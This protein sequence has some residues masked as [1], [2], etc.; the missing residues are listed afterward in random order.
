MMDGLDIAAAR[1]SAAGLLGFLLLGACASDAALRPT[2]GLSTGPV[3]DFAVPIQ[4]FEDRRFATVVRQQY[5]FSCGSAALATLLRYHYALNQDEEASF[6]GMWAAGDRAQIRRVGFSLLDM[7]RHLATL[8]YQADGF[9]V[10]LDEIVDAGV[11]GIALIDIN[12]YKH[13][14]V[15]KG[16]SPAEVLVGDPALGLKTMPAGEFKAAWNG[17]YFALNSKLDVGR[18]NFNKAAAWSQFARARTGPGLTD[19][20][21]Q[22]ALMLTAPFFREF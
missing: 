11:P 22:Q 19:P 1:R 17:I 12:G 16:V 10:T 5:D 4:S 15:V 3:G 20:V 7:K 9:K 8:G 21:S 18:R 2:M 14:V 13:F 6:R